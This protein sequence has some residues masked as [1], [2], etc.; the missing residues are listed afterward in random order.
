VNQYRSLIESCVMLACRCVVCVV[1]V[2]VKD[3]PAKVRLSFVL[4]AQVLIMVWFQWNEAGKLKCITGIM[5]V[6]SDSDRDYLI[7]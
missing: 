2:N 4:V 7:F 1:E 3:A 6:R 5:V